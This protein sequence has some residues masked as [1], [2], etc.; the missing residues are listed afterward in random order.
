MPVERRNHMRQECPKRMVFD[1]PET[2]PVFKQ[3]RDEHGGP[4][5]NR[6]EQDRPDQRRA[7]VAADR[8]RR[9][10]DKHCFSDDE[11]PAGN[12]HEA[13]ERCTVIGNEQVRRQQDQVKADEKKIVGGN[14]SRSS[15]RKKAPTRR[16]TPTG[17]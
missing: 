7:I 6:F 12:Q 9:V 3:T 5:E 4:I 14:I 16:A 11:R 15:R 17:A 8:S 1:K 13:A 2:D 10:G